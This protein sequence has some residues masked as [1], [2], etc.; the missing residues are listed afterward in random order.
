[1]V[2]DVDEI[3]RTYYAALLETVNDG[4]KAILVKRGFTPQLVWKCTLNVDMEKVGIMKRALTALSSQAVL[5]GD[6]YKCSKGRW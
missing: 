2:S 4:C 5:K 3:T 1:M 6:W